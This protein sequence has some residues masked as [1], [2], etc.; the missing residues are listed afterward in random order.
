MDDRE[1]YDHADAVGE[2]DA[3]R[4]QT[5]SAP[6]LPIGPRAVVLEG[7]YAR[8]RPVNQADYAYLYDLSLMPENSARWRY[9]GTSPSPEQFVADLWSGT[10]AQFLIEAREPRA[11]AG[12][13]VAYNADLANGTVFLGVLIEPALHKK[14]WPL[15]GVF[16][17]VDYLFR[18]WPLRKVYAEAPEFSALAFASGNKNL[19]VEEGRLREHQFFQDRYWDY[20]YLAV[21]R[22]RWESRGRPLL[23]GFSGLR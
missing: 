16:L 19:F 23:A 15:E 2:G 4:A 6:A 3:A 14:S 10:L 11:R 20:V 9:R 1:H 18:N 17:F 21:T 5:A 7:T 13:T 12:L 22:E 8:L